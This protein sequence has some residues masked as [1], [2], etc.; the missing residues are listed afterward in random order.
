MRWQGLL[1]PSLF[2]GHFPGAGKSFFVGTLL[3]SPIGATDPYRQVLFIDMRLQL[4]HS[5]IPLC[6]GVANAGVTVWQLGTTQIPLGM[7]V[8]ATSTSSNAAASYTG[9]AA[10]NPTVLKPP[11]VPNPGPGNFDIQ[12][13]S[14]GG[15]PGMSIPLA[16]SFFG[17][18]VEFSVANQVCAY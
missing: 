1:Y 4:V 12:L 13:P 11:P 2:N 10:Y 5:L 9:A 6:F 3:L 15:I 17:F 8:T 16:G 14:T 18:S 7:S